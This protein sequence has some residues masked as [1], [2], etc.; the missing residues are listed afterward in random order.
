MINADAPTPIRGNEGGE[1]W[2]L[3]P[4]RRYLRGALVGLGVLLIAF[5]AASGAKEGEPAGWAVLAM[6]LVGAVLYAVDRPR[7]DLEPRPW[8]DKAGGRSGLLLP[9]AGFRWGT[10]YLFAVGAVACLVGPVVALVVAAGEGGLAKALLATA[11]LWLLGLLFVAATVGGVRSRVRSGLGLL[12][13]PDQVWLTMQFKPAS[14]RWDDVVAVRAHWSRYRPA[15]DLFRSPEDRID[16]FLTLEAP[17]E[18]VA[19]TVFV[20]GAVRVDGLTLDV[21][22]LAIDPY[23]ALAVVRHYLDHPGE[24]AELDSTSAVER[25]ASLRRELA[26]G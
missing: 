10:V 25:V 12:L 5:A 15:K 13:G 21:R 26:A 9:A 8:V 20:R 3:A 18:D 1:G 6:L 19:G 4:R 17:G 11:L 7:R 22:R 16:N 24:R 14:L 2:H 23:L